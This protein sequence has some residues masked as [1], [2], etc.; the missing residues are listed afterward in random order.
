MTDARD[1]L[2]AWL[3]GGMLAAGVEVALAIDPEPCLA[4]N[5]GRFPD[6]VRGRPEV[7]V[8]CDPAAGAGEAAGS[9]AA[10][11]L[12]AE[13]MA[14]ALAGLGAPMAARFGPAGTL[15]LTMG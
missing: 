8:A 2:D 10:A 14:D 4:F 15:W 13:G 7:A 3:V 1:E 11:P 6:F 12:A 9:D 5:F